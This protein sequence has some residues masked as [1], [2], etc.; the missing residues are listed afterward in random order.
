MGGRSRGDAKITR[1]LRPQS[2]YDAAAHVESCGWFFKDARQ[3]STVENQKLRYSCCGEPMMTLAC[4]PP[5][6]ARDC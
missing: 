2:S 5:P 4:G 1:P 3:R 6:L